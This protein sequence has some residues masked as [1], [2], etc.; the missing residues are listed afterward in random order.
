VNPSQRLGRLWQQQGP[1]LRIKRSPGK[2]VRG[3]IADIQV[4]VGLQ[5]LEFHQWSP[6]AQGRV[7]LATGKQGS[8]QKR[9]TPA[10]PACCGF[11]G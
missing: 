1:S 11:F 10:I 2:V 6:I 8:K 7:S 4:D 3:G 5:L 9:V